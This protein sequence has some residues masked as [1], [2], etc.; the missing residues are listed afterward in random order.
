MHKRNKR[1]HIGI[2]MLL[3]SGVSF[4]ASEPK[5]ISLPDTPQPKN[6]IVVR[7]LPDGT[8]IRKEEIVQSVGDSM[9]QTRFGKHAIAKGFNS[10]MMAEEAK[11]KFGTEKDSSGFVTQWRWS[12]GLNYNNVTARFPLEIKENGNSYS[13]TLGCPKS[14]E[15]DVKDLSITGILKWNYDEIGKN[16]V[17]ACQA[18]NVEIRRKA[19]VKG[20]ITTKFPEGAVAANFK[21]KLKLAGSG[22]VQGVTTQVLNKKDE[23]RYYLLQG[24]NRDVPVGVS[25]YPYRSGSKVVYDIGYSY[26]VLGDQTT[27]YNASEIDG[28]RKSLESIAND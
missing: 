9:K 3:V 4:G 5:E 19:N 8:V 24:S 23:V 7:Q 20:E 6:F 2:M 21:R 14:L 16:V 27:T 1:S 12:K 18:A 17:A 11:V 10:K 25:V 15:S 28:L 13:V 26:A 22:H